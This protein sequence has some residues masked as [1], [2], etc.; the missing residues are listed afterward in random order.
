MSTAVMVA[1]PASSLAAYVA[2]LKVTLTASLSR[3]VRVAA[4]GVPRL[5]LG[6]AVV[7]VR[8]TVSSSSLNPSSLIETANVSLSSPGTKVSVPLAAA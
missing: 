5:A 4:A 1:V 3:M 2:L 6:L 8:A 7:R